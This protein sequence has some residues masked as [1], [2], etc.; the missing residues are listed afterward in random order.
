MTIGENIDMDTQEIS[1]CLKVLSRAR[2]LAQIWINHSGGGY[3]ATSVSII[4]GR[5]QN[6]KI[7]FYKQLTS[8]GMSYYNPSYTEIDGGYL[9]DNDE[10]RVKA[11]A[12]K[13]REEEIERERVRE[14]TV[15]EKIINFENSAEYREYARLKNDRYRFYHYTPN[16]NF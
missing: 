1:S 5:D 15:E 12:K 4:Q 7:V 10:E 13:F 14:K 16:W 9:L 11:D 2:E 8:S 3:T 6:I